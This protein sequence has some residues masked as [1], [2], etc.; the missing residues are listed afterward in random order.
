MVSQLQVLSKILKTKDFSIVTSNNLTEDYFFNYKQE[1]NYIKNHVGTTGSVP[2][3]MTFLASFPDFKIQDVSEPDSYLIGQ[4]ISDYNACTLTKTFNRMKTLIENNQIDDAVQLYEDSKSSIRKGGA[5]T[6]IDLTKNVDRYQHYTEME[7]NRDKYFLSTG[8][9]ELDDRIYGID[10]LNEDMVIAARTG[11]G[12]SWML[13]IMAASAAKAGKVVGLYSGEMSTDKVGYRVDTL[14]SGVS[15]KAITHGDMRAN[16]M[17]KSYINNL[18]SM[19]LGPIKVLTPNMVSG[20]VTVDALEAFVDKEGIEILLIDQYSLLDDVSKTTVMHEKVANISKA[21]KRLQV[22]KQIPIISVAQMN[23]T[24]NEDKS[25]D[26]TQIGLSDRIGQDAT[27][28]LM[29]DRKA[30]NEDGYEGGKTQDQLIINIV[31]SRDGGFGKLT[32]AAD[33]NEGKFTFIPEKM[34][35]DD[36]KAMHDSYEGEPIM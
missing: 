30:V 14:L 18:P 4:I 10:T 22:K 27:T 31:K 8:L 11:I 25:Q 34:N 32:Y 20:P 6:C 17:Y 29:L 33:F 7:A 26:T 23:R 36:A 1:F 5:V 9:K 2:D 3:S 24:K 21:I 28:I 16:K 15:N 19:G 13:L 12:K 35:Q